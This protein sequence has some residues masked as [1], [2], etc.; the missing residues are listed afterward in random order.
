MLALP[1]AVTAG[2]SLYIEQEN[3]IADK[4]EYTPS[5]RGYVCY[6][7][8]MLSLPALS[9]CMM[10]FDLFLY[11]L[12]L[13]FHILQHFSEKNVFTLLYKISTYQT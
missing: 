9:A 11:L 8:C 12:A 7:C 2:A 5:K 10:H 3:L 1:H 4:P 6:N 13:Q